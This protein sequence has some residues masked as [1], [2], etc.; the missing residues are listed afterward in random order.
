MWDRK[1]VSQPAVTNAA[2]IVSSVAVSSAAVNVPCVSAE[3]LCPVVL[4]SGF[5][6]FGERYWYVTHRSRAL[7][8]E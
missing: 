6:G 2:G 5:L 3:D 8:N 7:M 4:I 1:E